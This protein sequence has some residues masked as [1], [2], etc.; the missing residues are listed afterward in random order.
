[1]STI[2]ITGAT[3]GI[4]FQVAKLAAEKG[5]DL[6]ITYN[7]DVPSAK[8]AL[9]TLSK[10]TK[11][12]VCLKV[13]LAKKKDIEK[14]F[15][16]IKNFSRLE[17]LV[18]NAAVNVNRSPFENNNIKDVKKIFE[19]NYFGY[20]YCSQLAYKIF[21]KQ[22]K[23][24]NKSIVFISSQAALFGG[25]LFTHYAP[26]KAAINTLTKGLSREAIKHNIRVNSVSPGIIMT[27]GMLK[28]N[29][30]NLS[31]ISKS[32]P[33]KR[34]GHPKEVADVILKISEKESEGIYGN[35]VPVSGG[36]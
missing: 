19:V 34:I 1:M 6:C 16:S 25:N 30:M 5:Y 24:L 10:L 26:T 23:K 21:K 7:K 4:G 35:I 36:R 9:R 2:I 18:N 28:V 17:I 14:I 33:I 12:I 27:E 8:K 20:Y 31:N 15:K 22:D 11:K 32:I 3:K 29:K 13:D